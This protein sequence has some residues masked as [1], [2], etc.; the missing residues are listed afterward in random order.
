MGCS[1]GTLLVLGRSGG[2]LSRTLPKISS[3]RDIGIFGEVEGANAGQLREK[4]CT[5]CCRCSLLVPYRNTRA[6]FEVW[7]AAWSITMTTTSR[8]G[9]RRAVLFI[10][11]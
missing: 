11:I 10:P 6:L 3:E 2:E 1:C 7:T 4:T 9:R 5:I 8:G